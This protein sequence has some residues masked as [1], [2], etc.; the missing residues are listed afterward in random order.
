MNKNFTLSFLFIFSCFFYTSIHAQCPSGYAEIELTTQA[1]VDDFFLV[2]YPDCDH[3]PHNIKLTIGFEEDDHTPEQLAA[4]DITNLDALSN[5]VAIW[6]NLALENCPQLTDITGLS[7]LTV[8]HPDGEL[9]IENCDALESL[10]GLQ[11]LG[12]CHNLEIKDN[13]ALTDISALENLSAV[14]GEFVLKDNSILTACDAL[15]K[16]VLNGITG[17]IE[18]EDNGG[19][20]CDDFNEFENFCELFALPAELTMFKGYAMERSNMLVWETES[21]EN[22]MAFLVERSLN[23]KNNF[24]EIG[25]LNAAGNSTVTLHYEIEDEN[26]VSL[27]YYRLRVVDFDGSFEFSD[28]IVVQRSKTDIDLVEVFPVPAEDE[29]TVLVHAKSSGK[30]IITLSD[31]MG[32]KIKEER[33]ELQAGI[34]SFE[35][36]WLE[37]ETNFYYLTIYNGDERIAKKILRASRD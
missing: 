24:R 8:V 4:N 18:V 37:N 9:E 6:G 7:N 11:G 28:I 26:P 12:S 13:D 5:L 2:Q 3:I 1:E 34:N 32:R 16:A 35:L 20:P 31:F 33:V 14:S 22:T 27:A 30:A 36:N 23:G 25:R 21:E 19:Y 29:V 10:D 17:D 15:C